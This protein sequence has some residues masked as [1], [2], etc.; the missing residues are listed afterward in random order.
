MRLFRPFY[1]RSNGSLLVYDCPESL[2]TALRDNFDQSNKAFQ[3]LLSTAHAATSIPGVVLPFFTGLAIQKFGQSSIIV[4]VGL[5]VLAGQ[6]LFTT[7]VCIRTQ[8]LLV[9]GRFLL[10]SGSGGLAIITYNLI[11]EDFG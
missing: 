4:I 6:L 11:A 2:G 7:A 10:G 1:G 5:A 3:R 8:W 9:F